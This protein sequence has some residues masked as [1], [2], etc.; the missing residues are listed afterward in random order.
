VTVPPTPQVA[1]AASAQPG[2]PRIAFLTYS[3]GLFDS[4]THRMARSAAEAG[5]AAVI[6]ARWEPGLAFEE[7]VEGFRVVRAPADWRFAFPLTR[8]A[9]RRR[10]LN[11]RAGAAPASGGPPRRR[12]LSGLLRRLARAPGLSIVAEPVRQLVMFAI[13]PYGWAVALEDVVEPADLWHGM[14]AGSLP[15]LARF[16]SRHGGR[17]IYDSRDI[18]LHARSFDRS[19]RLL[20]AAFRWLERRWANRVDAVITVNDAYAA[21]LA[22]TLGRQIAAVVRNCPPRYEPPRPPPDLIRERLGLPASTA[23]VLHQGNLQTD[24]GIEEG[25]SAI[26]EVTGAALVILGFGALHDDLAEATSRDPWRD[27]VF[28][29]DAVPPSQLLDWTASAD[30]LLMAIQPTSLNH[31]YTTPN[32]L[33]EALAAGVP[34]VASDLPGMAEIVRETGAGVLCDP[35]SPAAIAAAIREVLSKSP[36]ERGDLRRRALAAA[37]DRYNWEVQAG[38]LLDLYRTL[39]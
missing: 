31:R 29:I 8:G 1:A 9:A 21:I 25:M 33:W 28:L 27:R 12:R 35:T 37:H 38:A 13:R 32:K 10:L 14:W 6:Y 24:R 34:I 17:T 4:R 30:V 15:A 36:A 5:Y 23:I 20:R 22:R 39:A 11:R 18:Y 26:L 7:E 3:T 19:P 16:R 2:R